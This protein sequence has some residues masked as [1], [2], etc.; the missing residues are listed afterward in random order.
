M[1][2]AET[3]PELLLAAAVSR[4]IRNSRR[5]QQL[6]QA[7]VAART[8]GLVSKAA[9]ANYETGHRGL[10]VD[11][12]WVIAGALGEDLGTLVGRAESEAGLPY[13]RQSAVSPAP[14]GQAAARAVPHQADL[15][16][17]PDK[18]SG[19]IRVNVADVQA[20][21]DPRLA[22]A[23]RWL[24]LRAEMT[25]DDGAIAA[26]ASLMRVSVI[27]CRGLLLSTARQASP[28]RTSPA[29]ITEA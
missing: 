25:L 26:L 5:R 6:T 7:D 23:K 10:R 22:A 12:L 17:A 2:H 19:P 29:A 18:G 8:G 9:L 27:E 15:P 4:A 28:A 14:R 20:S 21:T 24:D 3:R 11:V 1:T 16:S 13:P